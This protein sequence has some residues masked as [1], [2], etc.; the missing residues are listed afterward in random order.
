[1]SSHSSESIFAFTQHFSNGQLYQ[2]DLRHKCLAE[3]N[4]VPLASTHTPLVLA[5]QAITLS[6]LLE[7]VKTL[8]AG[9]SMCFVRAHR[10]HMRFAST[11]LTL[12]LPKSI[13]DKLQSTQLLTL[14]KRFSIDIIK[15]SQLSL[16]TPGLVVFDMDST[17]IQMEC[18]DEIAALVGVKSEVAEVTAK[19]MRGEIAFAD[20]LHHRVA[21]LAGV[22]LDKLLQLRESLPFTP[23]FMSL[24][25]ILKQHAWRVAIASGGFTYFAD[26]IKVLFDLDEAASNVLETNA[27]CLTGKVLGD[28]VDA[29][30][31]AELL[32]QWCDDYDI[33]RSQS[34]AV[35]DGANDLV[36]MQSAGLGVAVH[37]KPAVNEKADTAIIYAGLEAVLYTFS[38]AQ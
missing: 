16:E 24:V 3:T 9:H 36:M 21:C 38:E 12:Y 14:A 35:G 7:V 2:V 13:L 15:P 18:I 26:H 32:E 6:I 37:A 22:P 10:D 23:G 4:E 27:N 25:Q 1:M 31:K 5:G 19:A 20:S 33:P 34:I 17:I 8:S 30:K 29:N 28:I 11:V